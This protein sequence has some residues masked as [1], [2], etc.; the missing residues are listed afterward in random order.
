MFLR[1]EHLADRQCAARD[2]AL[3]GPYT[4][5]ETQGIDIVR[6]QRTRSADR[7]QAGDSKKLAAARVY[8][9]VTGVGLAGGAIQDAEHPESVWVLHL[10]S[11]AGEGCKW[12]SSEMLAC[13]GRLEPVWRSTDISGERL[14]GLFSKFGGGK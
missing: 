13:I 3:L 7:K 9:I 8:E 1:Y 14:M 10:G 11:D 5:L 6:F 12:K 2:W 4:E